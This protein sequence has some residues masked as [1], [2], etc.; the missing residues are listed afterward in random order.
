RGLGAWK[1]RWQVAK[2]SQPA[3]LGA[4]ESERTPLVTQ[5]PR[6]RYPSMFEPLDISA[7][8]IL[9]SS[10]AVLRPTTYDPYPCCAPR[11]HVISTEHTPAISPYLPPHGALVLPFIEESVDPT[12][13]S[14]LTALTSIM[15]QNTMEPISEMAMHQ[16]FL[17]QLAG[18]EASLFDRDIPTPPFFS[19]DSTGT[20]GPAGRQ[21]SGSISGRGV[22]SPTSAQGSGI[23]PIGG[24]SNGRG[25]S[26]LPDPR[27]QALM[28]LV[29]MPS[30]LPPGT[31]SPTDASSNPNTPMMHM[32]PY[33]THYMLP[34][35][36]IMPHSLVTNVPAPIGLNSG[37]P[38][39][40][41]GTWTD[42]VNAYW[43]PM[44]LPAFSAPLINSGGLA[45]TIRDARLA[46]MRKTN[47]L[48][49]LLTHVEARPYICTV[50]G[51]DQAFKQKWLLDR[52][53]RVHAA[54]N[55]KPKPP[56]KAQTKE[57]PVAAPSRRAR[58][59]IATELDNEIDELAGD[60]DSYMSRQAG[61]VEV[62][63]F[64]GAAIRSRPR[65]AAAVA[66]VAA[67]RNRR[68]DEDIDF[69]DDG[70]EEEDDEDD[71]DEVSRE[72]VLMEEDIDDEDEEEADDQAHRNRAGVANAG[73]G[74][75]R[76]RP[77][78]RG[79]LPLMS[80]SGD[81]RLKGVVAPFSN[82]RT[83]QSTD[84][85]GLAPAAEGTEE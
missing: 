61:D 83:E 69:G 54:N 53:G 84:P 71:E 64:E 48:K 9:V 80:M 82:A 17:S 55:T 45:A 39:D 19:G 7:P 73:T 44:G 1:E 50:P 6:A 49:H 77:A 30:Q 81:Y 10:M 41:V 28:Q 78:G 4:G 42:S 34:N 47:L 38:A 20:D 23:P 62:D 14:I 31:Q 24:T 27:A 60:G 59:T 70:E 52:H 11:D 18:S 2:T 68:W 85:N 21:H 29:P 63:G 3:S 56:R 79:K 51:C 43:Q 57:R 74:R 76:G 35:G 25:I 32:P 13:I 5:H 46:W 15:S 58:K 66:A 75:P 22:K 33:S 16:Q 65:R 67:N 26:R 72:D 36:G 8:A 12:H 37:N 40:Q